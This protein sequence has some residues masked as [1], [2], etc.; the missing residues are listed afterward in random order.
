MTTYKNGENHIWTDGRPVAAAQ[1]ILRGQ[2]TWLKND[3]TLVDDEASGQAAYPFGVAI[4][5]LTAGKMGTVVKLGIVLAL[6]KDSETIA[7]GDL[8]TF[9]ATTGKFEVAA[10]TERVCGIARSAT[11]GGT[12]ELFE[13]ELFPSYRQAV[14]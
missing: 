13:L 12:G 5:D 9:S 14:P 6:A 8:I 1:T 10:T 7:V 2:M 4:E 3:N 11:T